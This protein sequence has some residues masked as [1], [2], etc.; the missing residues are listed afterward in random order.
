MGTGRRVQTDAGENE[1][2][3]KGKRVPPRFWKVLVDLR[4]THPGGKLELYYRTQDGDVPNWW[5]K[6]Y[7]VSNKYISLGPRPSLSNLKQHFKCQTHSAAV[8]A[9]RINS[10]TSTAARSRTRKTTPS[11][12]THKRTQ[13]PPAPH[14]KRTTRPPT[15]SIAKKKISQQA[16]GP[17]TPAVPVASTSSTIH[18]Q[19]EDAMFPRVRLEELYPQPMTRYE[20]EGEDEDE[21]EDAAAWFCVDFGLDADDAKVLRRVGFSDDARIEAFARRAGEGTMNLLMEG[22]KEEGMPCAARLL[23]RQGLLERAARHA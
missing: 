22:L 12:P 6:C 18:A 10:R 2:V 4:K 8:R 5:V 3:G 23:V 16:W 7:C 1:V 20:G 14:E 19:E 21:D 11:R 9:A 17:T 13:I 15:T